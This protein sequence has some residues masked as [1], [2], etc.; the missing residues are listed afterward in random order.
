[1][2]FNSLPKA[3]KIPWSTMKDLQDKEQVGRNLYI[4]HNNVTYDL[5][6]AQTQKTVR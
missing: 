6:Q 5:L 3:K 2:P 4:R 1:M